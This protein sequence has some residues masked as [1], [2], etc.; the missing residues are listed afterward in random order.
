MINIPFTVLGNYRNAIG[1]IKPGRYSDCFF[2]NNSPF[3][4]P[5]AA[6]QVTVATARRN[7]PTIANRRVRFPALSGSAAAIRN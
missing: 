5:I 1:K 3:R 7:F 4:K 6:P 2:H